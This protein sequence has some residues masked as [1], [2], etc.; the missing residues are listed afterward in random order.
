LKTFRELYC[1]QHQLPF[2]KFERHLVFRC[3]HWQAK[4][5]WWLL[6]M[7]REY[8]SADFEFVRGVGDLRQRRG[9]RNEAAEFHYHPANRGFLRT[10]LRMRVS[11][12]ALQR[13]FEQVIVAGNS[14]PPMP[15]SSA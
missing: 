1:E 7:N 2:E 5:L 4:P 8:Y 9:F 13:L 6:F 15:T 14:R 10:V 12:Q 3:L 11:T